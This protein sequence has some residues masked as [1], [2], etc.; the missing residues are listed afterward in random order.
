MLR[1]QANTEE[2]RASSHGCDRH[3]YITIGIK[4]SLTCCAMHTKQSLS[5]RH[6]QTSQLR[7]RNGSDTQQAEHT[8]QLQRQSKHRAEQARARVTRL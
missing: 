7:L 2:A 5:Q 6:K 3:N 8:K 1:E 4:P